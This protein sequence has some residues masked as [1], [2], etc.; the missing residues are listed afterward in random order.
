MTFEHAGGDWTDKEIA[1]F[2][3][4]ETKLIAL[5]MTEND[6][7]K[8]AETLLYR[9]RPDS[10]DGRRLCLECASWKDRCRTPKAGYCT[11]PTV[12]QRCDGFAVKAEAAR[13][14]GMGK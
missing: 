6:A 5:N 12:L 3:N 10:G 9:D 2:T 4:R 7:E 8:L 13:L 1:R 11:V 14:G